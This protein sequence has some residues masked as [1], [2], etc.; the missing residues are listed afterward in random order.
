MVLFL[1]RKSKQAKP[2][3]PAVVWVTQ[4]CDFMLYLIWYNWDVSPTPLFTRALMIALWQVELGSVANYP[5]CFWSVG[6]G[7]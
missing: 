2:C 4:E 7:G 6:F 5:V 3:G 1:L